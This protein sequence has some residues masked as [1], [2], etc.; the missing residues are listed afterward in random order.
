MKLC[1]PALGSAVQLHKIMVF[2][3]W[4]SSWKDWLSW[5]H[6]DC[7]NH[8]ITSRL[9]WNYD[10]IIWLSR[11]KDGIEFTDI[12]RK[13][14]IHLVSDSIH[15]VCFGSPVLEGSLSTSYMPLS[16]T[17]SQPLCL[18]LFQPGIFNLQG[19]SLVPVYLKS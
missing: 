2:Y 19:S 4:V 18:L 13:E 17:L 5:H 1:S 11:K 12:G 7:R 9:D 8:L 10:T 14:L 3:T 16:E 15:C 6:R